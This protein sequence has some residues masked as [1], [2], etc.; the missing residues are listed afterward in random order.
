MVVENSQENSLKMQGENM[1]KSTFKK[2]LQVQLKGFKNGLVLR[3]T[4]N[5]GDE[6]PGF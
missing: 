5:P 3:E 4:K 6:S 1:S 2:G